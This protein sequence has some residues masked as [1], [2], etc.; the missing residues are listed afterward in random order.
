MRRVALAFA[1]VAL[2]AACGSSKSSRQTTTRTTP[3]TAYLT[4]VRV[5]GD[6]VTFAFKSAPSQVKATFQPKSQL[7]ECGSG[8][9][10][11]LKGAAFAVVHF[12]PAASAEFEGEKVVPT[13]TGPKRISGPGP[14]LEIAKFCDFEADLGW[15]VGVAKNL[16]IHVSRAG[17][18]VTVRFD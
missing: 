9:P 3:E 7:A 1:V 2:A 16:T 6:A 17:S 18:T 14:V 8:R 5:T 10:V 12:Q 13:Y 4:D 11:R 15:A